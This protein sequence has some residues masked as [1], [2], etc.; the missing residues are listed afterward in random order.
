MFARR[1]PA[2]QCGTARTEDAGDG[3]RLCLRI[4]QWREAGQR[5]VIRAGPAIIVRHSR[6]H[7]PAFHRPG[8]LAWLKAG[9]GEAGEMFQ[10]P[11]CRRGR[12]ACSPSDRTGA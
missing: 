7:T 11:R 8:W 10:P 1:I 6:R 3:L 2:E 9:I 12:A 4:G 5:A